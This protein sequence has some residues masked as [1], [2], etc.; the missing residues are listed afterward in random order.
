MAH[1]SHKLSSSLE[2]ALAGGGDPAT[3]PL[4]VFGPFLKALV[5]AGVAQVTFGASIWLA[6]ATVVMVSA[7]YRMVMVWVTD[8]SGGSGLNEEEFGPWAVKINAGI[9]VVEYT[10]TFL[11]SMAAL[12][13]FIADRLPVLNESVGGVPLRTVIA[14][15]LSVLV[16]FAV[17]R[18]PRVAARA[19]GPATAAILVLLWVLVGATILKRG[20]HLPELHLDAFRSEYI[21]FTLDGYARIL[22]LMTGIEIFANL[23]AAYNGTA[24]ERGRKAFGSLVIVMGTTS[25]SMII[26][27]PAIQALADPL[28]PTVSVFTQTMDQL[29]PGPLALVGTFIGIA[30]LLSAAA[31]SAQGLQNLALGLRYRH[32]LP[33]ALGQKNR[34]DVASLP[35]WLE[36]AICTLCFIF[37]GTHEETYLSLYAAG[38]F[39]LLS[40]TGWAAVKRL[41]REFRANRTLTKGSALGATTVAALLTSSATLIIFKDR[42]RDGAWAYFVLIPIFYVGFSIVRRRLGA[43]PKVEDRLGLLMSSSTLSP[44]ESQTFYSGMQFRR[45][46]LPLD[47]SPAAEQAMPIATAFARA[48]GSH[49][50]L[51]TVLADD[52]S[53][54]ATSS[55]QLYLDDVRAQLVAGGQP[56][57]AAIERGDVAEVIGASAQRDG[58]DVVTMTLGEGSTAL[59]WLARNVTQSVIYLTTPPLLLVRPTDQWGSTRTRFKRIVVALDGSE[60]AEQVLP[61]VHALARQFGS[62]VTLL[63]VPEGGDSDAIVEKLTSYLER[64]KQSLATRGVIA[65]CQIERSSPAQAIVRVAKEEQSDLVML[66]SHGRGGVERQ[67]QVKLGSVASFVLTHSACPVFFVSAQPPQQAPSTQ[68]IASAHLA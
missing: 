24:R 8:G 48:Y 65:K 21:G 14:A 23:V 67:E 55:A 7:M 9:T 11:V 66:V 52:A 61:F 3:S 39:V 56:T 68:P 1:V 15:V 18:G 31:A 30:V 2:G 59:R 25:V 19:F 38:V 58:T 42:F 35:V 43:P 62:A 53:P 28:D 5:V 20:F 51:L 57:S 16:G 36:V 41:G 33:A 34:F 50:S 47:G 49:V 6:V 17:N 64:I 4:Y 27:G 12:V 26:L 29:L 45:L 13:T 46:L 44:L 10:L 60:V 63:S 54:D 40:L 32:Y 22:A 37:F